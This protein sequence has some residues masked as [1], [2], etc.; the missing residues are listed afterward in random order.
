MLLGAKQAQISTEVKSFS[1]SFDILVT[2]LKEPNQILIFFHNFV[3]NYSRKIETRFNFCKRFK[4]SEKLIFIEK[5]VLF[6]FDVGFNYQSWLKVGSELRVDKTLTLQLSFEGFI[7][8]TLRGGGGTFITALVVAQLTERSLPT[9][10]I[11][12][13]NLNIGKVF[14]MHIAVSHN[15]EKTK[16]KKKRT[17]LARLKKGPLLC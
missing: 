3:R 1:S 8:L 10:E 13:L 7:F 2:V 14:R 9:S 15:S 17:G 5:S 11:H 4:A 6:S 16:I 12:G